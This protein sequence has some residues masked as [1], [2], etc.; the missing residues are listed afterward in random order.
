[1]LDADTQLLFW[2]IFMILYSILWVEPTILS[3]LLS[4]LKRKIWR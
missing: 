2:I 4:Y 3:E 1:M